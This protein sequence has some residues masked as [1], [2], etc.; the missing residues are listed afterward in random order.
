MKISMFQHLNGH[1]EPVLS[2]MVTNE[3]RFYSKNLVVDSVDEALIK[4]KQWLE[5]TYKCS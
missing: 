4:I 3:P 1:K 2:I 5:R